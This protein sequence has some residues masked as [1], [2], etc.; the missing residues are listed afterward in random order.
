MCDCHVSALFVV[1]SYFANFASD[2]SYPPRIYLNHRELLLPAGKKRT[3][4][5][6]SE[7]ETK[8]KQ[9]TQIRKGTSRVTDC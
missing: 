5:S 9:V 1:K 7:K 8:Q 2:M 6:D 3:E 4:T